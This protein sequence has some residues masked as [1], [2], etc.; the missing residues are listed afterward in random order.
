M[1]YTVYGKDNCPFCTAAKGLL[2]SK[3]LPFTYLTLGVDYTREELIEKC[4]PAI[5]RTVPQIF[6]GYG[7][8]VGG[9]T[10][11]QASLS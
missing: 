2:M 11:L 4:A 10:E 6:D 3:A 1:S 5:P 8:L 9:F 7:S